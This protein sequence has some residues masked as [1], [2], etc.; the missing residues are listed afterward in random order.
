M[1]I[2]SLSSAVLVGILTMFLGTPAKAVV[3]LSDNFNSYADNAA[4]QAAWALGT[5]T[6][7]S[8]ATLGTS[9][10]MPFVPTGTQS[11][12][13]NTLAP[14][15]SN[16]M[17]L[18]NGV[19]YRNLSM[20]VTQD[21]TV[22]ISILG[23]TYSRSFYFLMLDSATNSGYGVWW[24]G[25]NVNQNSANG[26]VSIRKLTNLDTSS[27][28]N[29][30]G[31]G[32]GGVQ[33]TG[34]ILGSFVNPRPTGDTTTTGMFIGYPVTAAPSNAVDAATYD[35][36]NWMGYVDWSLTWSASTGQLSL[37]ANGNLRSQVTDTT[38]SSF[39]RLYLK[40]GT[41]G[42]FD[43]ITVTA[44]PEPSVAALVGLACGTGSLVAWRRRRAV[45]TS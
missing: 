9:S 18:G 8:N 3:V 25:A 42:L 24:N 43:D 17:S 15:T 26:S 19:V 4:I 31:T 41:N 13:L 32:T 29:F 23:A 38:F 30:T 10:T 27:Y 2:P 44:V 40:G 39:N 1:K 36:N 12:A 22:D 14:M 37:Y 45:R 7:S 21:W 33:N 28:A 11:P 5:T 35:T 16:F 20:T 34:T 6:G